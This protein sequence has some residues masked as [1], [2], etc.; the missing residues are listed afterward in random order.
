MG[1]V[2]GTLTITYDNDGVDKAEKKVDGFKNKFEKLDKDLSKAT[3]GFS[4]TW[5]QVAKY[6]GIAAVAL[7]GLSGGIQI[8]GGLWS[9]VVALAGALAILPGM[10]AAL[11]VVI[12]VLALAKDGFK[13]LGSQLADL[14]PAWDALKLDVQRTLFKGIAQEIRSL[15]KDY[16]PILRTGLVDVAKSMNAAAFEFT[17]FLKQAQTQRDVNQL[18]QLTAQIVNNL[19]AAIAPL[20]SVFRDVG[21]VGASV[22]EQLTRNVGSVAEEFAGWV[23]GMRN[24]GQMEAW[25]KSG[26]EA[27]KQLISIVLILGGIFGEIFEAFDAAGVDFLGTI[28]QITTAIAQFLSSVEGQA[29]LREFASALKDIGSTLAQFLLTSLKELTPA[30]IELLPALAKLIEALSKSL[31]PV[32]EVLA[33]ALKNIAIF[34]SQNADA[35]SGAI[36][37][38][39][40]LAAAFKIAMIAAGLLNAILL[41]NPYV[42]LAA[43]II[44]LVALIIIYWDEIVAFTKKA[45][46]AVLDFLSATWEN[47]KRDCTNIWNS[48]VD[49]FKKFWPIILGIFTGGIGLLIGFIV[50][51]WDQIV[52]KTK[53]IWQGI[54]DFFTRIGQWIY[55]TFVQPMI[56][57]GLFLAATW[58][59]IVAEV[60]AFLTPII[61]IITGIFTIIHTV[62]T[63]ILTLIGLVL[64]KAW[65]VMRDSTI[66]IWT[67]ISTFLT[68]LWNS[69]VTIA[70]NV[71]NTV[72]AFF[73]EVWNR[74]VGIFHT[75]FDPII[76]WWTN[77]WTQIKDFITTTNQAIGDFV[78]AKWQEIKDFIMRTFGP[79]VEWFRDIWNKVS[80]SAGDGVNS[81]MSFITGL[82]GR[83]W[84]AVS[85][86]A[87]WLYQ[88][89]RDVIMGFLNGV[90][91]M[92]G[93]A[94]AEVK[95]MAGD[96]IAGAKSILGI[97]S[98][99][100]V[101]K[102]F[103][104]YTME[105][106]I[107]GVKGMTNPVLDTMAAVA[108]NI[109]NAGVIPPVTINPTVS[110]IGANTVGGDGASAAQ[111]LVI[112]GDVH[113]HVAGNL[114]PTKP[115]EFRETIKRIK[116]E[117]TTVDREES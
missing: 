93:N 115:V 25:M 52:A 10:F 81:V 68:D 2:H 64:L 83:I 37:A 42:L 16:L 90:R 109:A 105:G 61:E 77:L 1:S 53:E 62:I 65:Q 46:Q 88:T 71:W 4:K 117:L 94:V 21:V 13:E 15:A 58:T 59:K 104:Q 76:A 95:R 54:V 75:V 14:K 47:I 6:V 114:D 48:I 56:N 60:K 40:A 66:E 84:S 38:M 11:G 108:Q 97:R 23:N 101:F 35:V 41:L 112:D 103:G 31:L 73:T 18:M 63:T 49:F 100:T 107:V 22:F 98:P 5:L 44:A 26:I 20:A 57:L 29:V 39:I 55:D 8:L 7:G 78:S 24:S 17:G 30:L 32:I 34:I 69:I 70:T 12:G 82:P 74:I 111:T 106:Y 67:I 45:W 80:N 50:K 72:A 51:N 27:I 79:I 87:T 85:G 91:D 116:K 89:G 36:V 86:A 19:K 33:P 99:S 102:A 110:G 113:L 9:T 92:V 3:D 28:V 96:V 43:A